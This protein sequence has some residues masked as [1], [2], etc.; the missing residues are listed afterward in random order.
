MA[1]KLPSQP[2]LPKERAAE[3]IVE[4]LGALIVRGELREGDALPS[5][6]VLAERFGCARGTVRQAIHKL[7]DWGLLETR[8]GGTTRVADASRAYSV[9]VTELR[10]RLGPVDARERREMIERRMLQG[11]AMVALAELRVDRTEIERLIEVVASLETIEDASEA[12]K[13]E[14]EVWTSLAKMGNNRLFEREL[15]WW[16]RVV[17]T[18]R[19]EPAPS[20]MT[21]SVRFSFYKELLRRLRDGDAAARFYLEMTQLLLRSTT[22]SE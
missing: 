20:L 19:A 13:V 18:A 4:Q 21:P 5:E 17:E 14:S 11:V 3:Q 6:R 1:T 2:L 10:Y 12:W 9:E 8:Q 7:G 16:T 15:T 22:L